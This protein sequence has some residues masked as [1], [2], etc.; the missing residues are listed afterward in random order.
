[1]GNKL[2]VGNLDFQ[3]TSQ[4][5]IDL[6]SGAGEVR[7]AQ[8]ITDRD[9][10]RSKGFAFVEMATDAEALQA[11]SLYNGHVLNERALLVNEARPREARPNGGNFGYRANA[12][13]HPKFREVKHKVRGGRKARRF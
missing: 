11:I 4:D 13:A 9:T 3:T 7:R 8:V 10:Q 5:L 6:F 12:G 1:M 2:Y